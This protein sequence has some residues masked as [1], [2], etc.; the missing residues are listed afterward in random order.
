MSSVP[1]SA[2]KLDQALI[3]VEFLVYCFKLDGKIVY[4][5]STFR[6]DTRL[7]EHKN[8]SS[9]ASRLM[10]GLRH[11]GQENF[12]YERLEVVQT[13]EERAKALETYFMEKYKTICE[14]TNE[15]AKL[16]FSEQNTSSKGFDIYRKWPD[17]YFGERSYKMNCIGAVNR[18]TA[19]KLIEEVGAE[20]ERKAQTQPLEPQTPEEQQQEEEEIFKAIEMAFGVSLFNK[21]FAEEQQQRQREEGKMEPYNADKA[22]AQKKTAE[23]DSEKMEVEAI[24]FDVDSP[25]ARARELRDHYDAMD[26]STYVDRLEVV[27]NLNSVAEYKRDEDEDLDAIIRSLVFPLHGD[28]KFNHEFVVEDGKEV[29]KWLPV[30]VSVAVSIFQMAYATCGE[31]EEAALLKAHAKETNP[32]VVK[33]QEW[34]EWI[35]ANQGRQPI[36]KCPRPDERTVHISMKDWRSG[37]NLTHTR[38]VKQLNRSTYLLLLRNISWF[39]TFCYG[40]RKST[41][42]KKHVLLAANMLQAGYGFAW[43]KGNF[44]RFPTKCGTCGSLYKPYNAATTYANGGVPENA[45]ILLVILGEMTKE[46]ADAWRARHASAEPYRKEKLRASLERQQARI[47]KEVP[48]LR[49]QVPKSNRKPAKKGDGVS[50]RKADSDV[51]RERGSRQKTGMEDGAE[52]ASPRTATP[53]V[54]D[55]PSPSLDCSCGEEDAAAQSPSLDFLSGE[56]EAAAPSPSLDAVGDE[57]DSD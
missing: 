18:K 29:T 32:D 13:T 45:S 42:T 37:T 57:N 30:Q 27:Q 24:A 6:G 17:I 46:R 52:A 5:G 4:V 7:L 1:P 10:E 28:R 2:R 3:V 36:E 38:G 50:K 41:R 40:T 11:Y 34:L 49:K 44:K 53:S 31:R 54:A 26:P 51:V 43:E 25:F 12:K 47:Q 15:Q 21:D 48:K 14:Y 22:K 35:I 9:S 16:K 39:E 56:N 23:E 8:L 33:A 19:R 20:W 55:A